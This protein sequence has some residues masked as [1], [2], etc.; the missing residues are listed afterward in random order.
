MKRRISLYFLLAAI[1]MSMSASQEKRQLP[2]MC[3]KFTA[4]LNTKTSSAYRINT[5]NYD[6]RLQEVPV[7]CYHQVRNW[8]K[9]DSKSARGY[10]VAPAKFKKQ[11]KTLLDSGYH[12]I[13]PDQL[14]SYISTNSKMPGK[15]I[16]VSFDDGTQGQ[17]TEALPVLTAAKIKAVFFIMT[18]VLNR[19]RYLSSQQVYTLSTQG[20]VIGCH[21]WDHHNI[22]HYEVD[23]WKTQ[24]EQPLH[25]LERITGG[26]IKY[27]AY[28]YGAWNESA[29]Q[30]LRTYGFLGAFQLAGKRDTENPAFTIRRIIVD[31]NWNEQQL[32]N[33]IKFSFK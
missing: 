5:F 9:S 31:G 17:F 29:I 33:A 10:I 20:H 26:P 24:V 12:F 1:C 3:T 32:L 7:L 15:P 16:M 8:E 13:L 27:F 2:F 22:T 18:V 21:T 6:V 11:I 14:V 30:A 28:P 4:D 25:Q 23:D 19:P